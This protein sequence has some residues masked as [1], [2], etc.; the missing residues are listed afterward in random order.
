MLLAS[1]F[2]VD[3][4]REFIEQVSY[5]YENMGITAA[6]GLPFLETLFPFLPLFLMI[7]FNIL[8][9]GTLK[10]YIYTYIGTLAGTIFIFVFMR[11][12]IIRLFGE[13]LQKSE[14]VQKAMRWIEKTHPLLHILVLSV[15]FSPTF[16]INY[17][18]GLTKMKFSRF[19]LITV[20]SRAV[21]LVICIPFGSTLVSYYNTGTV[22]GVTVLWLS[23]TGFVVLGS[24]LV[25]Q[26]TSRSVSRA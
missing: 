15:P 20:V 26:K 14:K 16:I 12:V 6:I 11:Y 19:L 24:I 21:L 10:G 18:M 13:S 25:G 7:A 9:Y 1:E 23:I 4:L 22:G 3:D 17:S 2:T 5:F 8:A